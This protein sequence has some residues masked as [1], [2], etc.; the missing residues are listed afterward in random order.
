MRRLPVPDP[1]Q[2][3]A[4]S[5]TRYLLWLVRN[6][7]ATIFGGM[8]FG[9]LWMV[10]QALMP[11][12][13]G[14]TIDA[15]ITHRNSGELLRW[16]AAVLALG[17]TTATSGILRH[18]NA[19]VNFLAAG[20]STVQVVTRQAVRLGATLPKLVAAGDV[21]AVG[22]SD[23]AEIGGGLDVTARLAGAIVAIIAVAVIM[24]A[25]SVPLGLIVLVGVPIV[26]ALTGF[27]LR[28]LHERQQ[29]FRV[30]QGELTARAIDIAAGLRVLRGIGGEA[31][32]AERYRSESQGLRAAAVAVT[33]VESGLAAVEVLMPG[34]MVAAVTFVAA[35]FALDGKLTV[36]E[37]VAFYGYA[38]FLATPL[39][40]LMEAADN[41]T[42]AHVAARR[43]VRI[44]NLSP[45]IN[46]P[47]S[48]A[49]HE[50][51]TGATLADE[52]SGLRIA[53]GSLF[54]VV[55]AD[56]RDADSLAARLARFEDAGAPTLGGVPLAA[57]PVTEVRK[58]I[59]LSR[60]SDRFFTGTL[61]DELDTGGRATE[62]E[63]GAAIDA[64][65]AR[66]VVEALPDGLA[67]EVVDGG[68]TFSGGQLQ[69]LRLARALLARREITLLVEPT[70]AVD[71]HTEARI[72]ENLAALH[73]EGRGGALA[74]VLAGVGEGLVESRL[75][76]AAAALK[77]S[78][79][80]KASGV[81]EAQLGR[82][83]GRP[84]LR[85]EGQE[86]G[87]EMEA[88]AGTAVEADA[89]LMNQSARGCVGTEIPIQASMTQTST[90][91]SPSTS[92]PSLVP[93]VTLALGSVATAVDGAVP[94]TVATHA[95]PLATSAASLPANGTAKSPV[96]AS[97]TPLA[98]SAPPA[99]PPATSR[100]TTVMFTTSPLLLDR[101]HIVAYV[102][103]G[104]VAAVGTHRDLLLS[105]PRY[106]AVVTRGEDE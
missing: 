103:D 54:A 16:S 4:R 76:A 59:L 97:A 45:E 28:P 105:E 56:P 39:R 80:H 96:A 12:V 94:L 34:V 22:T 101:A 33:R 99:G 49:G 84:A 25:T 85:E 5:A 74:S 1:G 40:T 37:L 60:N 17:A 18:R 87:T 58:R 72:A 6:Q 98:T 77:V 48:T 10:S 86:T 19:L 36:G 73:A 93:A 89:E 79:V 15:G 3:D 104:R 88:D 52:E 26:T 51:P 106:A 7:R 38:A 78:D 90:L 70:S 41:M 31:A 20:Y 62:S 102:E 92:A 50:L 71:A 83:A 14:R 46:D 23:V 47:D 2:P 67:T 29:H 21:V 55:C 9:V 100:R 43:V 27:L 53:P 82:R 42:R 8:V 75:M 35:R 95:T 64:A 63:I 44:L 57:V 69:R 91:S 65:S 13:I 81:P 61:R 32:F 66:D 68:R 11:A 24:L 30:R